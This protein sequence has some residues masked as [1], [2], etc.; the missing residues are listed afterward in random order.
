MNYKIV[1]YSHSSYFDVLRVSI[2]QLEKYYPGEVF[3]IIADKQDDSFSHIHGYISYDENLSYKE[4]LKKAFKQIA[5][6]YGNTPILFLHEDFILY[7]N[8]VYELLNNCANNIKE[9][10]FDF[11]RFI[12]ADCYK[13]KGKIGLCKLEPD[14]PYIFAVQPTLWNT[15]SILRFLYSANGDTIYELELESTKQLNNGYIF[16]T[17]DESKVGQSHYESKVFPYMATAIVRGQ[18]N[19]EY[20]KKIEA[21]SINTSVRGWWA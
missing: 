18:W 1:I 19:S 11:I 10:G 5:H 8:P 17:G 3:D 6:H 9:L 4:R 14:S 15:E 21:L 16:I 12:Y 13:I 2:K 7:D 20:R